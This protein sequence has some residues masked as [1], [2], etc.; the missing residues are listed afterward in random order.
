MKN[1]LRLPNHITGG[2]ESAIPTN[3]QF[4][5]K[6]DSKRWGELG[7][8]AFV[9]KSTSVGITASRPYGDR[10]P[11]DFLVEAGRRLFRVQ[12]KAV[13]TA[14]KGHRGYSIA[15]CQHH[16]KGRL[17]YTSEDIDFIAAYV[18]PYGAWYLI[19]VD[20]VGNRK[21]VRLYPNG[22]KKQGAGLFEHYR[23]A[24]HLLKS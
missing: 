19:P 4:K 2:G 7:E 15:T 6:K 11:Y 9:M 22:V 8:L 3:K 17:T 21:F 18:A 10:K 16:L 12:V 23:E 13:F 24:W 1:E 14:Q 20:A 5:T